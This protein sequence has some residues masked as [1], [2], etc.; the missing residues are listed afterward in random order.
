M[1]NYNKLSTHLYTNRTTGPERHRNKDE[2]S[3]NSGLQ[4][5]LVL[6]LNISIG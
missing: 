1:M 4:C 6:C 2:E 5:V 3:G